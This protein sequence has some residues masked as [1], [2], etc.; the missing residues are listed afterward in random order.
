MEEKYL[1]TE[2]LKIVALTPSQLKLWTENV[3]ELERELGCSC[4]AEPM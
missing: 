3:E 2:R 4:R 1:E